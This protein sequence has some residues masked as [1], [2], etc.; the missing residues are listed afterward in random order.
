[1]T[2][3][4][5]NYLQDVSTIKEELQ[6]AQKCFYG[7]LQLKDNAQG[8]DFIEEYENAKADVSVIAENFSKK[9]PKSD[10]G[11]FSDFDDQIKQGI[12][13][14]DEV[15][16]MAVTGS[17]EEE[18]QLKIVDMQKDMDKIT[19]S[20]S[21]MASDCDNRIQESKE[22]VNSKFKS[23]KKNS[24]A[25]LIVIIVISAVILCMIE[26]SV[27][28]ILRK[29]TKKINDI[30]KGIEAGEGNLKERLL[31]TSSDEIGQISKGIN[32]FINTLQQVMNNI[33]TSADTLQVS[34]YEVEN[35]VHK[36]DDAITNTS[37][38]MEEMSAGMQNVSDTI[39]NINTEAEKV[40][41]ELNSIRQQTLKGLELAKEIKEKA[42]KLS[43]NASQSQKNTGEMISEITGGLER[44]IEESRK[45]DKI[46]ELTD[47]ILNISN[48]TN[49]LALN[50]SI[51]AARAGEAGKGFAVVADEIRILAD[52]SKETA[53]DIQRVSDLVTRS[54]NTLTQNSARMLEYIHKVILSDYDVM[55]DTGTSYHDDAECFEAMMQELQ[56]SA[57]EVKTTMEV[58]VE[59]VNKVKSVISECAVGTEN[60]AENSTELVADMGEVIEHMNRNNNIVVKLQ[61]E[62]GRFKYL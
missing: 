36:A 28:R 50:A 16:N 43:N 59:S 60:V 4:Q 35:R 54:V 21:Q 15:M 52:G 56:V 57:S 24:Q 11:G 41:M 22:N 62:I 29:P 7:Y 1:M 37:A 58:M 48:Q 33:K 47:N 13:D 49:L 44:A 51:E 53:N 2:E 39:E 32:L 5:I 30:V 34:T 46:N 20:I 40:D 12:D 19:E 42:V 25:M 8:E 45:V 26:K 14:M 18:I 9:I 3:S 31:V 10:K 27:I 23:S 61:N 38:T 17:S 6:K 55:A